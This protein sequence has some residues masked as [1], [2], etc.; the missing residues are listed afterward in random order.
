MERDRKRQVEA[1][2][3]VTGA[4]GYIG[5][6][7][8]RKLLAVG[9][10][11]RTLTGHPDRP[12]PFAGRVPA[13]AFRFEDPA[14]LARSLEGAT[15]LYNTYWV[16]FPRREATFER[17]VEHSRR[18]FAAAR[19]AGVGRIVHVSITNPSPESPFPYFRGKAETERLLAGTGLSYAI[20][21][22]TVVF[23][24]GDILINNIAWLLRRFPAFAI[25]GRGDYRL[26]PVF[27]GDLAE[28][29]VAA[30]QER[31]DRVMDAAGPEVLT[32]EGLVL[33]IAGALGR[34]VRLAHL[35]PQA[36]HLLARL[37]GGVVGDVVL[38][39]DEVGGLMAGLLV[40]ASPP[41]GRTP[42]S[43]WLREHAV[44]VGRMYASELRRHYV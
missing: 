27:L 5:Q 30:G 10:Q 25:P 23:G 18:L 38:T 40:S 2:D 26:Q 20:L 41:T 39:R 35:P 7:I 24:E 3:V 28:L 32:F 42:L 16:R 21:R 29:A 19:E 33:L 43:A 4:Y 12:D 13:Q 22:P 6:A 44:S 14:A 11:V 9:H 34:R 36:A 1:W 37:I 31:A 15:T 8:T 17:A